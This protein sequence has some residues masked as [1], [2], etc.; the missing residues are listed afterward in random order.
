MA[1][2]G[3]PSNPM[4][5]MHTA[6]IFSDMSIDGPEIGTLVLIVDRAKNL[7]NRK[8]I[9]KQ[10]PYCAARLGKE[11]K[12]TTT[13]IRGGQTPKWD[14][15][16]RF[17]VH[18]SP[19]YYQLKLSVFNDDK[20]TELIG[21][22][23]IDLRDII[24]P[25]GGQS[26]HW[27]TLS[28]KG[29]YAG[30]IRIEITYYDSRPKPEPVAAKPKPVTSSSDSDLL[31]NAQKPAVK[32]RPLPSD[33]VTGKAPVP[34]P[35]PVHTPPRPQPNPAPVSIPNQSPLQAVEYTTPPA[36]R[37]GQHD[38]HTPVHAS[39]SKYTTPPQRDYQPPGG[40]RDLYHTPSHESDPFH[41]PHALHS[42]PHELDNSSPYNGHP[43]YST[44]SLPI[45]HQRSFENTE[46]PPP[47]PMHRVRNSNP[48]SPD[49]MHRSSLDMVQHQ[50]TPPMRQNVLR[51][52]AHRMSVSSPSS[53]YPGRPSYRPYDSAPVVQNSPQ[54]NETNADPS[55][56]HNSYDSA[57][58]SYHR[59][60]QPTVEDVPE[61][62]TPPR[63]RPRESISQY[64]EPKYNPNVS[65][66]ALALSRRGPA[67]PEQYS[68]SRSRPSH[69][70]YY[71]QGSSAAP[72][73]GGDYSQALISRGSAYQ[74]LDRYQNHPDDLDNTQL[75]HRRSYEP[76]PDIPTALVPGSD[77]GMALE[78]AG[79]FC[80][81]KR[82]E[83]RYTAGPGDMVVHSRGRQYSEPPVHYPTNH[84][85]HVHQSS[86]SR[87]YD[88]GA[89]PYSTSPQAA[90]TPTSYED[91]RRVSPSPAANHTIKRKSVSPAPP[92]SDTRRLSGVPFGPDSYDA[93]NPTAAT[94]REASSSSVNY[95]TADGKIVTHDGREVDPSDHLPMDTWAP[96]PE[97]KK[98]APS[99]ET[100]SRPVP[101]GAQPMPPSGRR[102]LRIAARPSSAIVAPAP[103]TFSTPDPTPPGSASRNRLQKKNHRA[104]IMPAPVS[105]TSPL[106]PA[107]A[108][109][110]NSTPPRALVR[111]STFDYE[112][113]GVYDS[114]PGGSRPGYG[115]APPIPAKVPM[116]SGGLGPSPS[117]PRG[118][119]D[120]TLMEEMSRI[121]IG[122][123]R[124]RRHGGY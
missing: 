70:D 90:T 117:A 96:E 100:R 93:F 76:P 122:T 118:H 66:S 74:Q 4:N 121:D 115:S 14:Q 30:E 42:R 40:E 78:V 111:A 79:R 99:T 113:H 2:K 47:P 114:E 67:P 73:S 107:S 94:S 5:G 71:G 21:E 53:A 109:Q 54:Y 8:T 57:Y 20:R 10:D 9:G 24:V 105:S 116:M 18:D 88:R 97:Q 45:Q 48:N 108:H 49:A 77:P 58:E 84:P 46:Q 104:S 23:W 43:N 33:P 80:E 120:F 35:E 17:T 31:A 44:Q 64:D 28:C 62:W 89:I 123:G 112:N 36:N 92:P 3:K 12:K 7:P 102:P 55:P 50:S 22:T 15:E 106:G 82:H 59:Q 65:P 119:E 81:D 124:A 34:L 72:M 19:D 61:T 63:P 27:H 60:M 16:L 25:G 51:K 87:G 6:G 68:P 52:E 32:R 56:R 83:R 91:P 37:Y 101:A 13:D 98:P 75:H 41:Q 39:A 69:H 110:R 11:A 29:K 85:P 86:S 95:T 38:S 26:D 1:S 103:A